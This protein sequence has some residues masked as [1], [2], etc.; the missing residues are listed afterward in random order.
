M[1]QQNDLTFKEKKDTL[2]HMFNRID[3]IL[4]LVL[5]L[6]GAHQRRG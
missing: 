6:R 3:N 4:A 1:I 2:K 5:L